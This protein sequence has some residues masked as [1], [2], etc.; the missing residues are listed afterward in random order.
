VTKWVEIEA[1]QIHP[2]ASPQW[3]GVHVGNASL[4]LMKDLG[5]T[6]QMH[7]PVWTELAARVVTCEHIGDSSVRQQSV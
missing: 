3:R 7:M 5:R 2:L 4:S 6:L 1:V